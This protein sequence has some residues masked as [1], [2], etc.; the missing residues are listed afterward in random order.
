MSWIG[1]PATR[2]VGYWHILAAPGRDIAAAEDCLAD[3]LERALTRW[4]D[5]GIPANPEAW[6]LTVARNRCATCGSHPPTG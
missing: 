1:S 6:V 5:V 2:T 4:R 3:A